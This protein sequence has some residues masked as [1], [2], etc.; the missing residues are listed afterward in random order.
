MLKSASQIAILAIAAAFLLVKC[1]TCY[2]VL[3]DDFSISQPGISTD[4]NAQTNTL[5]DPGLIGGRRVIVG[6][7]S[8][9]E[10]GC[11]SSSFAAA[12][13]G[14]MLS[15]TS[16]ADCGGAA[17]VSWSGQAGPNNLN[18][19]VSDYDGIEVEIASLVGAVDVNFTITSGGGPGFQL[20]RL[21]AVFTTP[22]KHLVRFSDFSNSP[23]QVDL[24]DLDSI[25][26]STTVHQ[27]NFVVYNS[28]Q[29]VPEPSSLLLAI[30]GSGF[31][32]PVRRRK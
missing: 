2:A 20:E 25:E 21:A 18:L 23:G 31:L 11:G 4:Q 12:V 27:G 5:V 13:S 3:I 29:V 28:V 26:I 24:N 9:S 30:I 8:A 19:D 10:G 22:G 32:R 6:G 7:G 1:K 16:G 15:I 14:G 17:T